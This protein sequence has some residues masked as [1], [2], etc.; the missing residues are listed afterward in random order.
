MIIHVA[1]IGGNDSFLDYQDKKNLLP[2]TDGIHPPVN[3]HAYAA[4]TGGKFL[5]RLGDCVSSKDAIVVVLLGR[6]L[7]RASKVIPRLK[8]CYPRVYV[9][10]KECGNFQI[11]RALDGPG[12]ISAYRR[13]LEMVDGVMYPSL[14]PP[15]F[16]GNECLRLPTPYPIDLE[17]WDRSIPIEQRK[18]IFL[19]TREWLV[20][21]RCHGLGI[22]LALSLADQAGTFVTAINRDG[23]KGRGFYQSAF[24]D[25]ISRGSLRI[26]EGRMPYLDYLDVMARHRLVFQWDRSG[27]PGQVAGDALLTRSICI[28]GNSA[29]ELD[30]FGHFLDVNEAGNYCGSL[31]TDDSFY[32]EQIEKSRSRAETNHL[33]FSA[34]RNRVAGLFGEQCPTL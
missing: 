6:K 20:P 29:I 17:S 34:F 11:D 16:S 4:A 7:S 1:N 3:Y 2:G 14:D 10:W 23:K 22:S 31:L 27:V 19:G 12:Q 30:A 28:G 26:I 32:G 33:S 5:S 25:S 9:A 21:S 24:G 13:I 18:G 15:P 8:E